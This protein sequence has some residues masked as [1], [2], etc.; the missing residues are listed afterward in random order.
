MIA[1]LINK[2]TIMG[3]DVQLSEDHKVLPY[4]IHDN[5][6]PVTTVIYNLC[7]LLTNILI[8]F[9]TYDIIF[10]KK[11]AIFSMLCGGR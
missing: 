4:T 2:V 11:L 9:N 6:G 1:Y 10:V 5:L 3:T 7:I 8:N